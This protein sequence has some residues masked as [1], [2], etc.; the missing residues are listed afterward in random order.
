MTNIYLRIAE[1]LEDA[2]ARRLEVALSWLKRNA[3]GD[4]ADA[5]AEGGPQ[6]ASDAVPPAYDDAVTQAMRPMD[7]GFVAGGNA[8]IDAALAK[9]DKARLIA[10]DFDAMSRRTMDW[11]VE[12]KF[13]LVREITQDQRDAIKVVVASNV[14]AGFGP[15]DT[16]LR[17]R[18]DL[19]VTL[20]LTAAQAEHVINYRRELEDLRAGALARSLRDGRFDRTVRRA[21]DTGEPMSDEQVDRMVGAYQRRYI[22]YRSMTIAR[23]ESLRATNLGAAASVN[24]ASEALP[25]SRI[26]KRWMATADSRTRDTHRALNGQTII[27]LDAPFVTTAG[28][29]IR[30]PLDPEAVAAETV[31]CVLSGTLVYANGVTATSRSE[32]DGDV[33]TFE[34]ADGADLSCTINH[35]VLTMRGWVLAHLLEVGDCIVRCRRSDWD[36]MVNDHEDGPSRIEDLEHALRTAG[37]ATS[38]T[39][40]M[41][42]VDFHNERRDG[43]VDVVS[44]DGHL[45]REL[46]AALRRH[47]EKDDLGRRL[48]GESSGPQI[49]ALRELF[50][51]SGHTTDGG[52]RGGDLMAARLLRHL[53]P[54]ESLSF[55][56]PTKNP[57]APQDAA[58]DRWARDTEALRQFVDGH[59]LVVETQKL[60]KIERYPWAGH[61]FNL[62]SDNGLYL[63][64]GL[65]NHNCRC[66]LAWRVL[67]GG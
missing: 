43:K 61:V 37:D 49:G 64:N 2:F 12:Y 11:L 36:F 53:A 46:K 40:Q 30:W 29:A 44:T 9:D 65:V 57:S 4:I 24:E 62:E 52:V 20:G 55:A 51:G 1:A 42:L 56:L 23:T 5:G 63:A 58:A 33:I 21:I 6:A 34:T 31:N 27:G 28:N 7:A 60:I 45:W 66:T 3:L 26:E 25:G 50:I 47:S 35:P 59:P 19:D 14:S 67:S 22:A 39:K 41:S 54:F 18:R 38:A 10:V 15:A 13:A 32:Y 17:L 8:A 48:L 16:A